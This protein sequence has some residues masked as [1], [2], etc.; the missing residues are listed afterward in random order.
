MIEP[1][2][3][4]LV[5]PI[6]AIGPPGPVALRCGDML[7]AQIDPA[8]RIGQALLTILQTGQQ[9]LQRVGLGVQ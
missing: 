5:L 6:G 3:A 4:I 7:A 8:V 2:A 1:A 9:R